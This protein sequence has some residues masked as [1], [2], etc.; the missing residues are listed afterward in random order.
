MGRQTGSF[1]C[2]ERCFDICFPLQHVLNDHLIGTWIM[3]QLYYNRSLDNFTAAVDYENKS[4]DRYNYLFRSTR[5]TIKYTYADLDLLVARLD[6]S[7]GVER[8]LGEHLVDL[9]VRLHHGYIDFMVFS[10]D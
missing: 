1:I 3:Q 6:V 8:G 5:A 7:D 10:S 9:A 4:L 2:I